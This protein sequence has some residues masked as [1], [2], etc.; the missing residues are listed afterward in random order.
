MAACTDSLIGTKHL[1]PHFAYVRGEGRRAKAYFNLKPY[2]IYGFQRWKT[3]TS[4]PL[5]RCRPFVQRIAKMG[6]EWL[7]GKPVQFKVQGYDDLSAF[8]NGTW[9]ANRMGSKAL[10]LARKASLIG[11]FVLKF[12]YDETQSPFPRIT[13]LEQAEQTRLYFD[14]HDTE[15]LLM[16]RIQYAVMDPTDGEWY[17][18]REDWT[19]AEYV[20]YDRIKV[21][22][23]SGLSQSASINP[24]DYS[25]TADNSQWVIKSREP[26]K[27][28]IIPVWLVRNRLSGDWYG[29]GD[30]WDLYDAVD[31]INF[32]RDL[33]HKD[34]QKR[35][36]PKTAYIDLDIPENESPAEN[37]AGAIVALESTGDARSGRVELLEPRGNARADIDQFARDLQRE[38][39]DA[40]GI[41]DLSPETLGGKGAMTAAVIR[42]VFDSTIRTTEEKR[43]LYGEDGF[44]MFFERMLIG[45]TNLGVLSAPKEA[46]VQCLWPSLI[47]L[48]PED[49]RAMTETY[50]SMVEKGLTTQKRAIRAIAVATDVNDSD[51]LLDEMAKDREANSPSKGK[52]AKEPTEPGS[53]NGEEDNQ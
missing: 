38:L 47:S 1:P 43:R 12:S 11:G 31:Q 33:G 24:Y 41:T 25:E 48:T 30:L 16:A 7:F 53:G 49:L 22:S 34:N 37:S 5:P 50:A 21:Q 3:E 4:G 17:W 28:R 10:D 8:I 19:D 45:L 23:A 13:A 36:N 44:C 14:A 29:C 39:F 52:S 15:T 18:H 26:N 51:A 40:A 35:V 9:S 27:F 46:D 6:A 2:P 42:M 20:V 32:T